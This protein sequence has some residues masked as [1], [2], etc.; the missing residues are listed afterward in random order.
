M[1]YDLYFYKKKGTALSEEQ[2]AN[3]LTDNLVPVNESGNQWFYENKDTEVYYSFDRNKPENDP[4]SIELYESFTDFDNTHFSFNLNFMRPVFFGLE[5]FQ[6]IEIFISDL[7]LYIL[8]PQS[9]FD[10]P[11][12]ESKKELFENWNTI[13]LRSSADYFEELQ[14]AYF[15]VE[16]S[17]KVWEYNFNRTRLQ[18]EIGE[19]YF[20]P[21]IFFFK[22]KKSNEV[23]TIASWTEHIPNVIPPAD[24]FLLT[25]RYKK[26]FKTIKDNILVSRETLFK[27]FGDY[28]DN[29]EF[30]D[31]KIIHPA[32][33]DKVKMKFNSLKPDNILTD[34]AIRLPMENLY[35]AKPE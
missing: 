12:K 33:A 30:K 4:E 25:R 6:F 26:L 22:T 11:Q 23:I 24:Y 16:K 32:N 10:N 35:N 20:V 21:R 13:N 1:S 5:A 9:S 27:N 15:P 31:C 18:Q 3:Y 7:N 2:I 34:F 14:S 17:N 8:N 19:Q 28:F 29:F